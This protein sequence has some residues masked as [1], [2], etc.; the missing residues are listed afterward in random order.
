MFGLSSVSKIS[1]ML[2]TSL[3]PEIAEVILYKLGIDKCFPVDMRKYCDLLNHDDQ[4]HAIEV[5][6]DSRRVI[7]VTPTYDDHRN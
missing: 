3:E 1:L 6:Q 2:Y 7:I 4:K 5:D